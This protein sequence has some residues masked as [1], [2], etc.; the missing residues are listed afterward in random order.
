M[1][2]SRAYIAGLGT[3]GVL[4]ACFLLLLMVGSAIV[5]F[6][7]APGQA[8]NDGLDRLDVSQGSRQ[9]AMANRAPVSGGHRAS[10]APA[11]RGDRS[12]AGVTR[13]ARRARIGAG[14]AAGAGGVEGDRAA[15][16]LTGA[17]GGGAPERSSAAAGQDAGQGSSGNGKPRPPAGQPPAQGDGAPGGGP[18][19]VS[20]VTGGLA[21]AEPDWSPDWAVTVV[22][23]SRGYPA[24]QS[25]DD[26]ISGLH[27]A[28]QIAE[29]FHAGTAERDDRIVTAGGRVLGVTALGGT[30]GEAR[31]RAYEAAERIEF[32]GRQMR[33][34]IA[35]RAVERVEA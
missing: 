13:G 27:E 1:K 22:L 21:G 16:G 17:A 6:Q 4:I 9:S 14:P 24:S 32:D 31:D 28:A 30:P 19:P 25:K 11:R 35:A 10:H 29:V 3:S 33:S 2:A 34:D 20:V 15:G 23:A 5:A 8:S 12:R 7:G 26:V 18:G